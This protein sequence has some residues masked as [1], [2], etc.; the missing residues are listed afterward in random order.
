[1]KTKPVNRRKKQEQLNLFEE[2]L[3]EN[4]RK[5]AEYKL[6][7]QVFETYWLVEV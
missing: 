3:L 5:K 1:M 4:G 7:G 2:H 6:I